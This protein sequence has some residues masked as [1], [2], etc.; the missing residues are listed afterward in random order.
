VV[1]KGVY[2]KFMIYA[3]RVRETKKKVEAR[4]EKLEYIQKD[5]VKF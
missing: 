1:E 3:I 2:E 4:K 5:C